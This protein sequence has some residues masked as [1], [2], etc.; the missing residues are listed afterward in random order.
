MAAVPIDELNGA[1]GDK[2]SS[3]SHLSADFSAREGPRVG[4]W[5]DFCMS[6]QRDGQDDMR[7]LNG[8]D[9]RNVLSDQYLRP[10]ALGGQQLRIFEPAKV[11]SDLREVDSPNATTAAAIQKEEA[12][13]EAAFEVV[14]ALFVA[15]A[16]RPGDFLD[17]MQKRLARAVRLSDASSSWFNR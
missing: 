3:G 17:G 8:Q 15:A 16:R 4:C 11:G 9:E 5:V 10:A 2:I 1:Q 12:E 7:S 6:P 13:E 14:W